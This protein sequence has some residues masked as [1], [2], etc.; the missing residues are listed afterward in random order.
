MSFALRFD[1]VDFDI[2]GAVL[3]GD[4]DFSLAQGELL[5]LL[6]PSGCGKSTTLRLAAGLEQPSRGEIY[7]NGQQVASPAKQVPPEKRGIGMVFQDYA[8]FPHLNVRDNIG[9]GLRKL[10]RA[11][12]E[13][14]TKL[15]LDRL[16]IA[17]L[18]DQF[19]HTLSGGEMQRVALARA[20]APSPAVVLLDEPFS[21]LDPQLRS[22]I[23]DDTL[24]LLKELG[25]AAI[26]VTHDAEEAMF[27]ADRIAVMKKGRIVQIDT[28]I[29]LYNRPLDPFAASFFGEIN[30][31]PSEVSGGKIATPLGTVPAKGFSENAPVD[32]VFRA[33]SI[34]F[35]LT[36]SIGPVLGQGRVVAS[37]LLGRGSLVHVAMFEGTPY[38]CHL[39]CRQNG[40]FMPA[41]GQ[42]LDVTVDLSKAL[43]FAR[44]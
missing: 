36:G 1:H 42:E 38:Q 18:I 10:P 21:E 14:R 25:A 29:H 2:S 23:R 15:L 20:L 40:I 19:P 43:L 37:R 8:L 31:F 44:K 41:I 34:G 26:M 3:L 35:S 4:L 9:F 6:G 39:H 33:E 22:E 32:V 16:H 5:C 12:R 17:H 30:I 24:H 11:E 28:P 27:M 7:L 13:R